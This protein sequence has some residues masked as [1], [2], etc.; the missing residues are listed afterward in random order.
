MKGLLFFLFL[1]LSEY[2]VLAQQGLKGEYF[3]GRNFNKK[4][5]TRIDPQINFSWNYNAPIPGMPNTDYSIR[6]TGRIQAPVSGDYEFTAIV[7]DGLRI[8]VGGI[9]VIDAWG[10]HDHEGVS[11]KVGMKAGQMYDLKIEYYNGIL[12][13]EIKL[14]WELPQNGKSLFERISNNHQTIDR[15]YFFLPPVPQAEPVQEAKPIQAKPDPEPKEKEELIVSIKPKDPEI[16][17]QPPAP[18]EKIAKPE[19]IREESPKPATPKTR[20]RMMDTIEKYTP[21]NILFEPGEPFLLEESYPELEKMVKLLK[22]FPSLKVLIEGHTDI[23]GDSK[24]NL[25]LSKDRASE[26]AYYLGQQGIEESRITTKGYGSTKPLFSKDST[27]KYPL[28][29]RVEFVVYQ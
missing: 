25:Q 6:W 15:K 13:G 10:P 9:K 5:Y 4:F 26:V 22:R 11:G 8:W 17:K 3:I 12:E 29:R 18:K 7:D 27:Q 2:R 14:K 16:K 28:N 23:T 1:F 21:K 19:A 20:T 24:V